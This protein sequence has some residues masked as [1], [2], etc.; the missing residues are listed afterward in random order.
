MAFFGALV[1]AQ[2]ADLQII[3]VLL[4]FAYAPALRALQQP[5]CPVFN[6][7]DGISIKNPCLKKYLNEKK[8]TFNS[9]PESRLPS[10]PRE[11]L[12]QLSN[13]RRQAWHNKVA[14]VAEAIVSDLVRQWPIPGLTKPQGNEFT[15]YFNVWATMP[16]IR[17]YFASWYKNL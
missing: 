11:T 4:A 10:R 6:L 2:D 16:Q 9:S 8:S 15:T 12:S 13:R 3:Q 17:E 14:K 7:R 1:F 5:Q